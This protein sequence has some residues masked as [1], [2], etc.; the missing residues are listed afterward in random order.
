MSAVETLD[1]NW[2]LIL[3]LIIVSLSLTLFALVD[4]IKA[5]ETQGPKW[6]WILI[7]LF[8]NMIGPV[9]YFVI[10]RRQ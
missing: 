8:I 2:S 3:P 9:L 10:G 5:A 6:M 4:C 7:I 1:I